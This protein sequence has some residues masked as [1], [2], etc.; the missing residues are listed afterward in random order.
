[1][2]EVAIDDPDAE[3]FRRWRGRR[4]DDPYPPEDLRFL[5]GIVDETGDEFAD[6]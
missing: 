5:E 2:T 1:M 6:D 3:L 4:Y